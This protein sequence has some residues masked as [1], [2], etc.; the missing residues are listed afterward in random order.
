MNIPQFWAKGTQGSISCWR[1]SDNSLQ[2]AQ[3]LAQAAAEA[4]ARQCKAKGAF[5]RDRYG[6]ADRPLREPILREIKLPSGVGAGAITRNAY[7]C[8]V[9]NTD[10]SLFIDVDFVEETTI[11]FLRSFLPRLLGKKKKWSK[12]L[13]EVEL[14]GRAGKVVQSSPGWGWRIY[15]TRAGFR[16]LA[17]HRT[18]DPKAA[19]WELVFQELGADPLYLRLCRSQKSFRA[20][21]TPKPWRCKVE[22]PPT[23]WPF[24][25]SKDEE[26]FKEWERGYL[27]TS[28]EFATCE[29]ITVLGNQQIHPELESIVAIHDQATRAD[30]KLELA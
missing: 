30:S 16:L 27:T 24:A 28:A 14:L 13:M 1:W 7:G 25:S 2:E 5:P 4:L 8:L 9:L 12:S 10:I 29:L 22:V 3:S 21:L 20:R 15:R 23:Q 11:D 19:D 18:F 26:K 6:Y 17:T